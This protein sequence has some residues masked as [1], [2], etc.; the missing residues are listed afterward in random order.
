MLE[1]WPPGS[2]AG[3][4]VVAGGGPRRRLGL[5][6]PRDRVLPPGNQLSSA[7][8]TSAAA[9]RTTAR[10]MPILLGRRLLIAI[11]PHLP[12][13]VSDRGERGSS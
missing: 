12:G 6:V 13:D 2:T 4:G 9:V 11:I 10:E 7:A 1:G 8:P 5:H 3:A